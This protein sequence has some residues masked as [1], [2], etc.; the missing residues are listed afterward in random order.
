[1]LVGIV[2]I[3]IGVNWYKTGI[4]TDVYHR[5]GFSISHWEVFCGAKP[6]EIVIDV[7][8]KR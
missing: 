4:Q 2:L 8:E 3:G 5:Q 6:A 7:K 1:M